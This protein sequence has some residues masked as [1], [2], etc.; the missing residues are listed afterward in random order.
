MCKGKRKWTFHSL[1]FQCG[2]L[3][4]SNSFRTR[5]CQNNNMF[6]ASICFPKRPHVTQ[7]LNTRSCLCQQTFYRNELPKKYSRQESLSA[8]ITYDKMKY[9]S[10][11]TYDEI[12]LICV[13]N[14]L[15]PTFVM[16]E[17]DSILTSSCLPT[18][19]RP[20]TDH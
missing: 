1:T 14:R 16:D 11:T 9:G 10:G 8:G 2:T 7:K 13:P 17:W 3:S 15:R 6:P 5:K 4:K 20:S 18:T 12:V 19:Y